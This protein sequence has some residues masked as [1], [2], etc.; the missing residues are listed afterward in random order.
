[1]N[2]ILIF[3]FVLLF[4]CSGKRNKEDKSKNSGVASSAVSGLDTVAELDVIKQS[5]LFDIAKDSKSLQALAQKSGWG[6]FFQG[7]MEKAIEAF[8]TRLPEQ[9]DAR[10]GAGR[11]A[12][13]MAAGYGRLESLRIALTPDILEAQ[14][15]RPGASIISGWHSF[16]KLRL[17]M[18][19]GKAIDAKDL[20]A[21]SSTGLG[22]ASSVFNGKPD[23]IAHLMNASGDYEGYTALAGMTELYERRLKFRAAL[24]SKPAARLEK[25][26]ARLNLDRPDLSLSEGGNTFELWDPSIADIGRRYYA[27]LALGFLGDSAGCYGYYRGLARILLGDFQQAE[28][29]FRALLSAPPKSLN[30][31]CN[32]LTEI[33]NENT[34]QR[35][36][37]E[38]LVYVTSAQGR[39]ADAEKILK[40]LPDKTIADKIGLGYARSRMGQKLKSNLLERRDVL[41]KTIVQGVTSLGSLGKGISDVMELALVDRYVDAVQRKWAD[42]LARSDKLAEAARA[43]VAAEDKVRAYELSGR[44]WFDSLAASAVDHYRIRQPR[45]ALKYLLRLA[46][47]LSAASALA[48][49]LRDVLSYRAMLGKGGGGVTVGQ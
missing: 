26:W 3:C 45:V 29:E 10:L 11:A 43:R 21:L 34:L 22:Q 1:M 49:Q 18:Q 48:E 17:K 38:A 47:K 4:G 6:P 12:L 32:V 16:I 14:R 20:E 9:L 40:T 33:L 13:R 35:V 2:R 37:T 19:A 44:N 7:E 39:Q 31:A 36:A 24:K 41:A 25:R 30:L 5:Y 8:R 46:R 23:A 27:S 28:K 15:S 42:A